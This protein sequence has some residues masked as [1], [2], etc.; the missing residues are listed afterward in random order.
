MATCLLLNPFCC[1]CLLAKQ[2]AG[3]AFLGYLILLRVITL[4]PQTAGLRDIRRSTYLISHPVPSNYVVRADKF[5][6]HV[7]CY[8]C[9]L[10][11]GQQAGAALLGLVNVVGVVTLS[12]LL[13]D[14]IAKLSLYRQGLGVVLG[15]LPYLQG[16]AAA[17][18]AIPAIRWFVDSRK[19]AAI[20]ERNDN[21]LQVGLVQWGFWGRCNLLCWSVC[22]FCKCLTLGFNKATLIIILLYIGVCC[23]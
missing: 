10:F 21:R 2:P 13:L 12:S 5:A 18:F 23:P 1:I 22:G 9:N 3:A 15:L 16:Y 14:P 8:V 17:F 6:Q 19:N 20:D 4:I 11:A 7:C